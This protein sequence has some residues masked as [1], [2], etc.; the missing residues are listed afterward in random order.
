MNTRLLIILLA[1]LLCPEFAPA[2]NRSGLSA[3]KHAIRSG[4]AWFDASNQVVNAHG[5][6]IVEDEG[7]YYLFGEFKTD[8]A[9]VFIGFGCYSSQD[10]M[11]WKFE[12]IVLPQ[13]TDGLLGPNRIGERVKVMKCPET[14]E[15]VMYMHTDNRTYTDPNI[16]YATSSTISG[17]YQFQGALLHEGSP[18][19]RWDMGTFQDTD[20]KG[21]LLIHH[22]MIYELSSDYKSAKRLVTSGQ[23]AGES[24]A[25]FKSGG[26]YYW[27][28][29]NLTSW[30]RN[31]N[32]YLTASSLEGP[33]THRGFFAPEG[34]LT[35]NSQC[36]F[37]FPIAREKDTLFLYTGDRW[38]FPK[39][40]AAATYVWQPILVKDGSMSLPVFQESWQADLARAAWRPVS[41]KKK[42]VPA[43]VQ[44][45]PE[46]W[47]ISD[48]AM[49]SNKKGATIT[50]PFK[51]RRVGITGISKNTGGYARVWILDSKG[52]EVVGTTVDFYSKY[53][54]SSLKFLSP[55]LP[56]GT[57][58]LCIE[59]LGEHGVWYNK[60]RDVF[61]STDDYVMIQDVFVAD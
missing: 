3:S 32:F 57:Y 40:A 38:S 53:A 1:A 59:V 6:C 14:G 24:P 31:D 20:G 37:V 18:I 13:Q 2:Q 25:M 19:R 46:N 50:Y 43:S 54:Y 10:L 47:E 49:T 33:W 44:S 9:N 27:L 56:K 35:W 29:S 11:N 52:K 12:R 34:T 42:T 17:V 39:Q 41:M 4:I 21:Y 28:S 48:G 51:G 60:A 7:R 23:K 36:S 16:G 58:T 5:S 55:L 26:L 15:F 45:A 22:G 8:S 30:E 61:G